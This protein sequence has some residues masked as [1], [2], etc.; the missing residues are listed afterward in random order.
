MNYYLIT[1]SIFALVVGTL[2]WRDVMKNSPKVTGEDLLM[3]F[4][5]WIFMP[6]FLIVMCLEKILEYCKLPIC[7]KHYFSRLTEHLMDNPFYKK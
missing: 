7:I 1:Y 3:L 5:C 2:V 4:L 6:S